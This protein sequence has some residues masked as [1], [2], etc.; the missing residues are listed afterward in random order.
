MDGGGGKADNLSLQL[1]IDHRAVGPAGGKIK[2]WLE[3]VEKSVL[4]SHPEDILLDVV[5]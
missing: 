1:S 3:E 2:A 5:D 4:M